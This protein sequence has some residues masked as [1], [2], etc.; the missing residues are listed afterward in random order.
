MR[1]RLPSAAG[2]RLFILG[3]CMVAFLAILPMFL[4][5]YIEREHQAQQQL[6]DLATHKKQE[7][8]SWMQRIDKDLERLAYLAGFRSHLTASLRAELLSAETLLNHRFL[9]DILLSY[10][11]PSGDF[12]EIFLMDRTGTIFYST[13]LQQLGKNKTSRRYFSQGLHAPYTQN[14]YHSI[15]LQSAGMTLSRPLVV[16]SSAGS[17][18]L[19]L[20]VLAARVDLEALQKLMASAT[21]DTESRSYLVNRYNFFI[22]P[23]EARLTSSFHYPKSTYTEGVNQCLKNRPSPRVYLDHEGTKVRGAGFWLP[24]HQLCLMVEEE[25][26]SG[27][28]LLVQQLFWLMIFLLPF[29]LVTWWLAPRLGFLQKKPTQSPALVD[30]RFLSLLGHEVRTPLNGIIGML[31]LLQESPLNPEQRQ[32]ARVADA[33]AQQLLNL[34]NHLIARARQGSGSYGQME[35]QWFQLNEPLDLLLRSFTRPADRKGLVLVFEDDTQLRGL[36]IHSQLTILLQIIS[37]L[38]ENAVK[39]TAKGKVILLLSSEPWGVT[40]RRISI[41]VKDTGPGIPLE[42]QSRIFQPFERLKADPD[43]PATSLGLGLAINKELAEQLDAE[44]TLKSAEGEGSRFTLFF[45]A[46]TRKLASDCPNG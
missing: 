27:A 6:Q 3:V 21:A 4:L 10:I 42:H 12:L 15:T 39:F 31:S 25:Y 23:P 22:T 35:C 41:E 9:N 11:R 43:H 38:L 45:V 5:S 26:Q 46:Q 37:N 40:Q 36:E 28:F 34:L 17:S 7:L 16:Q 8:E 2:P 20:G 18:Q 24:Q 44:L 14:I 19:T 30:S 13:D 29:S 1:D 33:S 32:Q